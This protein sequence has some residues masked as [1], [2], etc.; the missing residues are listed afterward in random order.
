MIHLQTNTFHYSLSVAGARWWVAVVASI[1]GQH[2]HEHGVHHLTLRMHHLPLRS[3]IL[4]CNRHLLPA[5][6]Y[7]LSLCSDSLLYCRSLCSLSRRFCIIIM[8]I[9]LPKENPSSSASS[10]SDFA[11]DF[12]GIRNGFDNPLPFFT[13]PPPTPL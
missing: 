11:F 6:L 1:F 5:K 8:L 4:A 12:R 2:R 9:I 7:S 3:S 10:L 13:D